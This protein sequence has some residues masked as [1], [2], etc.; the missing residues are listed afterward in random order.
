MVATCRW[1]NGHS[2][3]LY[4]TIEIFAFT[5]PRIWSV[6]TFT[7]GSAAAEDEEPISIVEGTSGRVGNDGGSM[8]GGGVHVPP[9]M[10]LIVVMNVSIGM[11]PE[12]ICDSPVAVSTRNVAGV[13]STPALPPAS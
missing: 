9:S 8:S 4:S 7:G 3:S 11:A 2:R 6:F 1:Q 13:P 12:S 10:E 5:F